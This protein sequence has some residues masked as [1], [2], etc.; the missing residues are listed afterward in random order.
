MNKTQIIV[1][2]GIIVLFVLLLF[3][4]TKLPPNKEEKKS[5]EHSTPNSEGM[6]TMLNVAKAG[7]TGAQK[8]MMEEMEGKL[9]SSPDKKSA[10][11]NIINQWDSLKQPTVAAYYMEQAAIA[12]P[13]EKNW[14]EA[15]KR[16]YASTR[17][18]K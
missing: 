18:V 17:F 4:D 9:K 1:I 2:S 15:G 5:S 16:Y 3:A 13:I 7:L 8:K 10:F 6:M 12:S 14:D 11:E